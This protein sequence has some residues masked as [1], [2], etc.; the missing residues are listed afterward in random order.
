MV[1]TLFENLPWV[2]GLL[3][4]F[5]FLAVQTWS[6]ERRRERE[7]LYRSEAIR[8]IAE[9]A[10]NVPEP[11][12]NL[13]RQAMEAWKEQ[14][15]PANMGP[16]Q[17]REYYRSQTLQR[18]AGEQTGGAEAALTFMREEQ[19]IQSLRNRAGL[20]LAGSICLAVGGVATIVLWRVLPAGPPIYLT[21]LIPATVGAILL[22]S[23]FFS[24]DDQET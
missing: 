14:P 15:S 11:V 3:G 22:A 5:S 6:K 10:P 16:I 13:L 24:S 1:Q 7:A 18:I 4:L 9:M 2:V 12:L 8:K 21:G 17:A 19:R 20:R 23:Y